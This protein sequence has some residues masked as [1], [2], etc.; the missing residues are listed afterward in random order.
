[1]TN[2]ALF[3]SGGGSNFRA[4]HDSSLAGRIAGRV[5]LVVTDKPECPGARYAREQGIEVFVYPAHDT[6]PTDLLQALED[7]ECQLVLLAG[8]LKMVPPEVVRAY[9]RRMLNIHPALLPA[10][11]GQGYYGRRVHQAVLQSGAAQS[12]VTVHFV[13]EQYD[14]GPIVAQATVPVLP[15]DTPESLAARVLVQEHLLYPRVVAALCRGELSWDDDGRPVLETA[16][17]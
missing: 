4:I 14:H 10:F 8:Y 15:G 2:L 1:M 12:G 11:G 7:R 13:D 16:I 5:A 3:V 6:Q 17:A 9:Q